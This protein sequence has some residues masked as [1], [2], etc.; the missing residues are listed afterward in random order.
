M[1][2][3]LRT[4]HETDLE[5]ALL[6]KS[7]GSLTAGRSTCADCGRTPLVGERMYRYG[8]HSA[9]CALCTPLRRAE[10]D[11]VELVRHFERGHT[12]KRVARH[13]A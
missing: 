6:R 8:R 3:T 4:L 11:A 12:V 9:V 2:R 13:A 1:A 7:V 5:A 10:P